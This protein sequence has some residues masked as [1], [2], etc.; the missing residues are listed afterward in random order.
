VAPDEDGTGVGTPPEP[1][2]GST[3]PAPEGGTQPTG[4]APDGSP[5]A[6]LARARSEAQRFRNDLRETKK[7]LAALKKAD[8]DRTDAEK[9]ELQK[10]QDQVNRLTTDLSSSDSRVKDAYLEVA[11]VNAATKLGIVDPDAAY[12]LLDKR[13]V[14]Y[15]GDRPTNIDALLTALVEAKPYLKAPTK[16]GGGGPTP[17]TTQPAT[18]GKKPLTREDVERMS[19]E[20]INERWDEVQKVLQVK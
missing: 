1:Q 16:G 19:S 7:E 14:E 3:P 15:D 17:S 10:M 4:T 11:V 12:R 13:Q 18:G 8:Q 20:E 2:T 9:T 6:E 5:E